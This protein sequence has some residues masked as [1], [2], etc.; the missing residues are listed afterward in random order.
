MV[1]AQ[2]QA[3]DG[4]QEV[5]AGVQ[6]GEGRASSGRPW[7][8]V[9]SSFFHPAAGLV[10]GFSQVLTTFLVANTDLG[11]EVEEGGGGWKG[12]G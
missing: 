7:G 3:L 8:P 12:R 6:V 10:D 2:I 9:R 4:V 11:P 5:G 1:G